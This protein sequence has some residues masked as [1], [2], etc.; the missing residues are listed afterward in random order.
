MVTGHWLLFD[1]DTCNR[2]GDEKHGK[3]NKTKN[4]E[5]GV[6]V[7]SIDNI[8]E[9]VDEIN[10]ANKVSSCIGDTDYIACKRICSCLL[11]DG[12]YINDQ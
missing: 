9:Y 7:S 8:W 12:M 11:M 2:G 4:L 5:L 3:T 6:L 10:G 1:R